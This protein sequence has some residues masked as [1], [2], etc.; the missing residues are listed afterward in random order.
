MH[1]NS[2]YGV[3]MLWWALVIIIVFAMIIWGIRTAKK[4]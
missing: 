4:K 2:F 3:H 1:N